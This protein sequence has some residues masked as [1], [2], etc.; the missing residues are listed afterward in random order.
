MPSIPEW[1]QQQLRP[2]VDRRVNELGK[3][4]FERLAALRTVVENRDTTVLEIVDVDP[5][6][7]F[8]LV[9]PPTRGRERLA[10]V[11]P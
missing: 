2:S 10:K 4:V 1:G 11:R 6:L 5:G 8:G 9:N 7:Q 3:L